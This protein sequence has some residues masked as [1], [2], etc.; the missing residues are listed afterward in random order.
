MFDVSDRFLHQLAADRRA[1]LQRSGRAPAR[2]VG[3]ALGAVLARLGLATGRG[4]SSAAP[5]PEER[6][7]M[8]DAPAGPTEVAGTAAAGAA[9]P[10]ASGTPAG[11]HR[12][13][14]PQA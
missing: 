13:G 5:L 11:Q 9:L 3:R 6:S 8:Q 1:S 7:S 2:P 10:R 14:A 4:R 12:R